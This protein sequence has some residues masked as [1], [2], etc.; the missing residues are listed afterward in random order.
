MYAALPHAEVG[1]LQVGDLDGAVA[2]VVVPVGLETVVLVGVPLALAEIAIR[3][4]SLQ[5]TVT[6]PEFFGSRS[7][8][9]AVI[10]CHV[11]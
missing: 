7:R 9:L 6:L 3:V 5:D 2:A 4:S 10:F 1:L 11:L 8:N